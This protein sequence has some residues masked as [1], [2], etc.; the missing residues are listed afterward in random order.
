MKSEL[1]R[2][3]DESD[4]A[5][6]YRSPRRVVHIDDSAI[7]AVREIYADCLKPR[8]SILDLMSSWRSHLPEHFEFSRVVGLG[9]NRED[10]ADNPAP[11]EIVIHDVNRQPRLPFSDASLDAAVM[12]VSVQYLTRPV[13]IF[14]E[15]GRIL[16]P[17]GPFVVVFSNRM[18]PTKAVA[19]W[20][21][22]RETERIRIVTSYFSRSDAF[23]E[24]E[25]LDRSRRDEPGDPIW[26]VIA[27]ARGAR[28]SQP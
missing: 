4:D 15:V 7:A 28:P 1:F 16:Q 8:S 17:G 27:R 11:T 6:F 12:A 18:F 21:A 2:R 3:V 22:A 20:Q 19:L 24:V 10:M 26:A 9:L 14:A 25:V 13:E 5:D 23:D